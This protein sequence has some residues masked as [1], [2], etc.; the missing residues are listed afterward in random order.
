M[1]FGS[2]PGPIS[3]R[4]TCHASFMTSLAKVIWFVLAL[5]AI[6]T[7]LASQTVMSGPS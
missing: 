4:R 5:F 3:T 1:A 6:L 7:L 2:P